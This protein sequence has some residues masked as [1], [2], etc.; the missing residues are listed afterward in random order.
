MSGARAPPWTDLASS[1]LAQLWQQWLAPQFKVNRANCHTA[2]EIED[3][4]FAF[5]V[6]T[7]LVISSAFQKCCRLVRSWSPRG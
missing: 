2:K 1:L 4:F 6:A 3:Q 7:L 5:D